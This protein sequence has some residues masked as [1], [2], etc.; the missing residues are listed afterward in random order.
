MQIVHLSLTNFK[1][2]A[3]ASL[4][5]SEKI[6]C[7]LGNNGM[8]K[9]NLLDAIHYLSFCKSFSGMT[10]AMLIRMGEDFLTAKADYV[11]RDAPEQLT[12][13]MQRGRRKSLR[14]GGKEYQRLSEHI[15]RYPLVMASPQ[16]ID[17]IQG[18]GEQRRRWMDM[19]ISQSDHIYLD[20]VIRYTML[21]DQR[22]RLLRDGA[23]DG[24]LYEALEAGMEMAAAIIT[25][26]RSAW[27]DTL[28]GLFARYYSLIASSTEKVEIGYLN[29]IAVD[30]HASLSDALEASRRRDEIL[31]HT[32]VG[33]HRD[34]ITM[35]LNDM[36]LR[37]SG[38]QGQCKTF[39]IA[40]RLAQYDFLHKA[41]GLKPLLLLD[42]I[43]DKLDADRVER[44]MNIVT[45]DGQ[46]GQIFITDTNR[47]HLDDI[48]SRMPGNFSLWTVA[49]G[50]FTPA[51]P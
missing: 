26:R 3:E 34:D 29:S 28:T 8:G 40:L 13:G 45:T 15:G 49:D 2:I 11:R 17:L 32:T 37:R 24:T 21:L 46:F 20:A 1:N 30:G 50:Q 25:S 9:S 33:P 43:F 6:N 10:D 22:N 19:V 4:D 5:F 23:T 41:T 12:L 39:T 36:P 47:K 48:I 31:H 35:T 38:S 51:N 18:S 27:V 16:D 42:D 44:I 14:R 7:F